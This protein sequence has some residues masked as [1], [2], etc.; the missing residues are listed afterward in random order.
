MIYHNKYILMII[1]PMMRYV[2][3]EYIDNR[4]ISIIEYVNDISIV[5]IHQW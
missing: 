2:D 1:I 5:E 3:D 4:N